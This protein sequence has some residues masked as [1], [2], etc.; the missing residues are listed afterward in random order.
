[1]QFLRLRVALASADL[2]IPVESYRPKRGAESHV[3]ST[4]TAI[5]ISFLLCVRFF[6]F[7]LSN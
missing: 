5:D 1:M 4:E 2:S 7:G 3:I 6:I